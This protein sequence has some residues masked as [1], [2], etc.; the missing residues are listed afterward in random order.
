[1]ADTEIAAPVKQRRIALIG[2]APNV[3][4]T[5]WSDPNIEIWGLNDQPWTM[6]RIDVLF[7]IHTPYVIKAEGHWDRM[8]ALTI[9][10]FMQD[11]YDEIPTSIKYPMDVVTQ[12]FLLEG[13]EKPYLTCSASLMLAVA[14]LSQ[15]R[16]VQIDIYGI[17]MAQ[18]H[19]FRE[20]RPSCEYFLGFAAGM[21]IKV[22]VQPTSDLMKTRFIYGFEDE[23]QTV[24]K[25][26][27]AERAKW[28]SDNLKQAENERTAA[29]EKYLQY[30][31]AISDCDHVRSRY[32]SM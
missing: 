20:Q 7:E 25:Q 11:H 3:R 8:K 12:S 31:G 10:V 26:Q 17:D 13:M 16:P 32:S 4:L 6:P 5:P 22:T 24:F 28:L 1:M 21:G 19:E 14:L 23:K 15:P 2:Y 30:L 18:T 9:P 29:H 27:L